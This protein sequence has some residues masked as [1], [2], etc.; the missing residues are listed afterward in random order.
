VA[1]RYAR[2]PGA[3]FEDLGDRVVLELDGRWFDLR[4]TSAA[5]WR[6]LETPLTDE[7]LGDACIE[8]F[9]GPEARIRLDVAAALREWRR[10][11][12]VR[13]L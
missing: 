11:G 8:E 5:I 6:R 9:A 3:S 12:L 1:E 4:G 7:E 2:A 13:P 10:L